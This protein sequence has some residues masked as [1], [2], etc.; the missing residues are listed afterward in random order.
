[1]DRN[2]PAFRAIVPS[3]QMIQRRDNGLDHY[4]LYFHYARPTDILRTLDALFMD[5]FV[6][7]HAWTSTCIKK[8]TMRLFCAS[9]MLL[10]FLHIV[11]HLL[12]QPVCLLEH[13]LYQLLHPNQ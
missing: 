8:M 10:L 7:A 6:Y 2:N 13:A 4:Y 5:K 11:H 9:A 3:F 1:M 12:L